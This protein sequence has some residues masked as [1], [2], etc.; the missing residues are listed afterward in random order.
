M[1]LSKFSFGPLQ[2]NAIFIGCSETKKA[3]VIDPSY[4]SAN[5]LLQKE[6]QT[7]CKIEKILLT[8]SHWDHFADAAKLKEITKADLYVHPLDQK[9]LLNPGCDRIPFWVPVERVSI[10]GLFQDG[11]IICVGKLK[12]QVIHTPGH[13]PG[14]VCFYIED[15]KTIISG[16]TLFQGSFG[17]LN[18]PTAEPDKMWDSLSKLAKL[19]AE[20]RVVPGHGPDT[21]IGRENWLSQAKDMFT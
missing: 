11:D 3:I 18:L 5:A 6:V 14:S 8:H 7:Q 9:N 16:D 17:N 1:I 2:T 13:S 19:P 12:L 21:T 4:G 15:Q 20:V 10:D